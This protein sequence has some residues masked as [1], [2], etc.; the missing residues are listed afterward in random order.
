M[1][2][3]TQSNVN[4]TIP[5]QAHWWPCITTE[6]VAH[7]PAVVQPLLITH[8]AALQHYQH[9]ITDLLS[10]PI[11]CVGRHTAERLRLCG[12]EHIRCRLKAEDVT[13][14][15]NTT[16]LHG[17]HHARNFAEDARV[18][19]IQTHRSVLNH[20]NIEKLLSSEPDSIHVYSAQVL[21]VLQT[22][23]WPRTTLY[24]VPSAPADK[25]LWHTVLQ[26]D[27]SDPLNHN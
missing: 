10:Q 23:S 21:T 3:Y 8:T 15:T 25:N 26:F 5:D 14:H 1:R 6:P 11:Q 20:H 17:D 12:F 19:A 2:V 27:P 24:T 9:A 13:I 18:T 4:H 16:W 7:E 22:R